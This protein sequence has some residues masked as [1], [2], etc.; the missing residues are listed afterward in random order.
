MRLGDTPDIPEETEFY[1]Q[2]KQERRMSKLYAEGVKNYDSDDEDADRD[3]FGVN[4]G[5]ETKGDK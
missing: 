4:S 1:E 3:M 5:E 2:Y